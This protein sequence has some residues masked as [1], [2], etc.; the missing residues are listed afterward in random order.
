MPRKPWPVILGSLESWEEPISGSVGRG[1]MMDTGD[2]PVGKQ[3]GELTKGSVALEICGSSE[4][5]RQTD[6][7]MD[8]RADRESSSCG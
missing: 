8:R 6:G 5:E 3:E 2:F 4:S 7:R 1:V